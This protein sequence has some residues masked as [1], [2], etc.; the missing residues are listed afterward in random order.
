MTF[1]LSR[2]PTPVSGGGMHDLLQ[3]NQ[4]ANFPYADEQDYEQRQHARQFDGGGPAAH[5]IQREPTNV[6]FHQA[7]AQVG[8]RDRRM[9]HLGPSFGRAVERSWR[10]GVRRRIIVSDSAD[11]LN[12]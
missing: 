9:E 11:L 7:I 5:G 4:P 6:R 2:Q 3:L 8:D 1:A 12:R 10:S